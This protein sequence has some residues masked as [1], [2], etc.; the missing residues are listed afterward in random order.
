MTW[1]L[2]ICTLHSWGMCGTYREFEYP[3]EKQ[4]YRAIDELYKNKG[5]QEYKYVVCSPKGNSI[6][7]GR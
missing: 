4:C 7:T 3:N 6:L 2:A 1:I 5:Q